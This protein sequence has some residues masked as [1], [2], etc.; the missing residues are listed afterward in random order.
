MRRP[1][2]FYHLCCCAAAL[3]GCARPETEGAADT[4]AGDTAAPAAA[5]ASPA[6][7]SLSALAGRWNVRTVPET[8]PDTTTTTS[9]L[10]ATADT[11][12]WTQTFP[13][14]QP[15]PVRVVAVAGDS[16][17]TEAGPFQSV[18]RRGVQVRTRTVWRLQGD[19]LVGTSVARYVTTGPDS[20]H[21][22]RSEGTRAP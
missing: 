19:R 9:V 20:V 17:V 14:R 8:G 6:T 2:G 7:L 22:A 15:I 10:N 12:G 18:R 3:A 13:N 4:A 5:P 16:A 11:T 1:P 21:P